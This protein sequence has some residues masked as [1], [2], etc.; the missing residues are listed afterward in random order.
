MCVRVCVRVCVLVRACVC[1]NT[2]ECNL[3]TCLYVSQVRGGSVGNS[4][5]SGTVL[6]AR[7]G[8]RSSLRTGRAQVSEHSSSSQ[9]VDM[10]ESSHASLV[11][12]PVCRACVCF[13]I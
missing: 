11:Y 2:M 8:G 12:L 1:V 4:G 6:S 7:D 5:S 3:V 10:D 9:A 13:I